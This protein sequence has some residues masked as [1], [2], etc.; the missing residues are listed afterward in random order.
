MTNKFTTPQYVEAINS[1]LFMASGKSSADIDYITVNG[2][3]IRFSFQSAN[4]ANIIM[5]AFEH[6]KCDP[7]E[8]VFPL[9]DDLRPEI[10]RRSFIPIA[11]VR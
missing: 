8:D 2:L 7:I 5:P 11:M 9:R 10:V 3:P 4:A 1:D 6:L